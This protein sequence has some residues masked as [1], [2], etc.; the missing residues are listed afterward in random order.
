MTTGK[1]K[2]RVDFVSGSYV[3]HATVESYGL[4]DA[5]D[6]AVYAMTDHEVDP[7]WPNLASEAVITVRV[8]G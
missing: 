2:W 5:I 6:R 3:D 4:V 1:R 8:V 7:D